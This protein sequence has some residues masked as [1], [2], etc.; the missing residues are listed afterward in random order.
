M[1]RLTNN[2]ADRLAADLD[3][4]AARLH[5][6]AAVEQ[7]Y[8]DGLAVVGDFRMSEYHCRASESARDDARQLQDYASRLRTRKPLWPVR[9]APSQVRARRPNSAMPGKR[10]RVA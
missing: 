7:R 8:A 9:S 2:D 4:A 3:A 6:L 1:H 5:H 10:R